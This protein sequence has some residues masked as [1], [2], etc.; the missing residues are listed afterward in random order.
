MRKSILSVNGHT[1]MNYLLQTIFEK[2]YHFVPVRD[3]F[4]AMHHFRTTRKINVL[5]ID[6]DF[7]PQQGWELIEHL[8]S[9]R[10][11]QV[12]VILLTT[13]NN[14]TLRQKCLKYEIEDVFYK[15]FNP[16]DLTASVKG[17]ITLNE[18]MNA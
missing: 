1:A 11:H 16:I 10:L 15:P 8:K 12:P 2:E 5:I 13:I 14:E 7:Q 3:V 17:I 9:S 6:I 4:Q 18:S